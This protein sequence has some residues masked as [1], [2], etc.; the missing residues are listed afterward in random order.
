MLG[1]GLNGRGTASTSEPSI[2]ASAAAQFVD[3]EKIVEGPVTVAE[4][5]VNTVRLRLGR[6]PQTVT[7]SLIIG[8][9]SKFPPDPERYYLGKTVRVFGRIRSF[10]GGLE[11]VVHDPELIEVADAPRTGTPAVDTTVRDDVEAL[12]QRVRDLEEQVQ[13]LQHPGGTP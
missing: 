1:L 2:T 4:R 3:Q 9:L 12:K 10:R 7:V 6:P 11:M 5:D 13:Q 8:L